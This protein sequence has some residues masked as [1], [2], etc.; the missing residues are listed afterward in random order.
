M[1]HLAHNFVALIESLET[2]GIA[3]GDLQHGNLLVAD[4]ASL[5]LVDY[6]GM[7]VPA[8]A[9]LQAAETGHR[10]YQAPMRSSEF[11]RTIDRF[12]AW[13]IYLS[14][15]ALV[16]QPTLWSQLRSGDGEYLLLAE[17]D[18]KNP[19][20][21][22]RFPSLLNHDS[23]TIRDL[24][25][26]VQGFTQFPTASVPPLEA[27]DLDSNS[28]YPNRL[29]AHPLSLAPS[30]GGGPPAWLLPHLQP[31][32]PPKM[33]R[34]SQRT[35]SDIAASVLLPVTA[36]ALCTCILIGL[37]PAAV[38][39]GIA[40][41]LLPAWLLVMYVEYR[42]RPEVRARH[43]CM[44][45]RARVRSQEK[46]L[47]RIEQDNG[48]KAARFEKAEIKR[49]DNVR[50]AREAIHKLHREQVEQADR[51]LQKRISQLAENTATMVQQRQSD[52]D[53]ALDER[54]REYIIA[55]LHKASLTN[56][57]L[58]GI[59]PKIISNLRDFGIT[60]A[61]DFIGIRFVQSGQK[62]I[63]LLVHR[64]GHEIKVPNIGEVKATTLESW[65]RSHLES[66]R[67]SMPTAVPNATRVAIN[68][69]YSAKEQQLKNAQEEIQ[70]Y[71]QDKKARIAQQLSAKM[72]ELSTQQKK[73]NVAAAQTRTD[74]DRDRASLQD[75]LDM[76]KPQIAQ[77]ETE[78]DSYLE[79][80]LMRFIAF[81]FAG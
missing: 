16:E 22:S 58:S 3:H 51:D 55:R 41:L 74:M 53:R 37:V 59:G 25:Q 56:A 35:R 78:A 4:D 1:A 10:N 60:T 57:K 44:A 66:A 61:A 73:S 12:S 2:H 48:R 38:A 23:E 27:V 26:R 52:L 47:R 11:H 5:R 67:K 42:R 21:S 43:A 64:S 54:Q 29:S 17:D 46:Q 71:M 8:L 72:V 76:L 68:S 6:D 18:F 19:A 65:R 32:S 7:F 80:K 49:N 30:Q 13:V 69:R 36:I 34:F 15:A 40:V 20:A 77:A 75:Q 28:L 9:K 79:I 45:R 33:V 39:T 81:A 14:L 70:R 62:N 24:S 50:R 31:V 63:P